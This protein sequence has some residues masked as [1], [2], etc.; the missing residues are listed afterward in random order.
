M[1]VIVQWATILSLHN[2]EGEAIKLIEAQSYCKI[3]K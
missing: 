2:M 3:P 1:N